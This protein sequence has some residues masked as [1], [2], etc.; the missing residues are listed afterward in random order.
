M[1]RC[2]GE[3][4]PGAL[5]QE[6][7]EREEGEERKRKERKERKEKEEVAKME[8]CFIFTTSQSV[9]QLLFS[10]SLPTYYVDSVLL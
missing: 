3:E 6:K 1:A 9:L 7:E 8:K 4:R 10:F 2:Y 5:L